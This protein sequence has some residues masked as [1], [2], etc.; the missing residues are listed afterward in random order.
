METV[1]AGW[2]TSHQRLAKIIRWVRARPRLADFLIAFVISAPFGARSLYLIINATRPPHSLGIWLAGVLSLAIVLEPI[3]LA[4]RRTAP[5]A[6]FVMVSIASLVQAAVPGAPSTLPSLAVFLFSLYAYCG[7]GQRR[8][9]A[10]SLTLGIAGAAVATAQLALNGQAA[11]GQVPLIVLFGTFCGVVL[12]AWSLGLFRRAQLVYVAV[13]EERA[14]RAEAEQEDRAQRA[15][16]DERARIAREMHDVIA[17]S[18]A[19]I[20]SQA[21]GGHYA[22]RTDP[23]RATQVLATIAQV[24]REALADTRGLLDVLRTDAPAP[25][26]IHWEPQPGLGELSELLERVRSTGLRVKYTERG[27][28]FRLGPAAQ[29][30]IYRLVQESLTNTLKH[31]G[32]GAEAAVRFDWATDELTLTVSDTGRGPKQRDRDGLGLVGM[33]ERL[34][35]IGGSVVTGPGHEGG[36][37]VRARLPRRAVLTGARE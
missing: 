26:A 25:S 3:P 16:L 24:G 32:R 13:L 15:V 35:C 37:V 29:V 19:V 5:L 4:C 31:A 18:L 23:T 10:V 30:A 20:V 27:P 21:Q 33:R 11:K 14:A 12:G 8:A 1:K 34:G 17:H 9:P 28:A 2:W 22:A 7:Y 6:S 36:F